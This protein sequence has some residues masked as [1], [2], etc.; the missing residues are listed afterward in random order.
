VPDDDLELCRA[1]RDT[2]RLAMRAR[3]TDGVAMAECVAILRLHRP[4]LA[5][6][7]ARRMVALMLAEE[8]TL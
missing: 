2:Y 4:Q 7:D 3:Y 8:P 1:I 5:D 6:A